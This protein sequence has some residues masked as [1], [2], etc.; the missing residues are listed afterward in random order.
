[1]LRYASGWRITM[2]HYEDRILG[3]PQCFRHHSASATLW[4][5]VWTMQ[6]SLGSVTTSQAGHRL[7]VWTVWQCPLWS[8]GQWH[9]SSTASIPLQFIHHLGQKMPPQPL[10]IKEKVVGDMEGYKYLRVES[11]V[12]RMDWKSNLQTV[13]KT[14]GLWRRWDPLTHAAR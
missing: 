8:G 14:C 1:M 13:Y 7:C 5:A 9:R 11:G 6:W 2:H 4:E 12:N 3:V 10:W